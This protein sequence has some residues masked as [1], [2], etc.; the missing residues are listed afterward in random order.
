MKQDGKLEEEAAAIYAELGSDPEK[1]AA[2]LK[3]RYGSKVTAEQIAA[4]DDPKQLVVDEGLA[5]LRTELGQLERYVLLQILDATW[6]DH[7]YA[8]DQLKESVGLRGYAEKDPRIEY[9]REG[10]NQYVNMQGV[11]QDRVTDLIFRARLTPNVR[12]QSPDPAQMQAAQPAAPSEANLEDAAPDA[13]VPRSL[14]R[15]GG[16]GEDPA[17]GGGNKSQYKSRKKRK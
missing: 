14:R 6:K 5:L 4:D 7:L 15:K 10:A 11:I 2:K 12:L 16:G 13:P 3:E 17:P 8:M 9:K 1:L